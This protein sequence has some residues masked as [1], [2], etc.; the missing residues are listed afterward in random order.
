M[1]EPFNIRAAAPEARGQQFGERQNPYLPPG[2][3]PMA[4][5]QFNGINTNTTRP[6]VPDDQCW[7]MDNF[8]PL[9][10]R[11]LRTMYGIGASVYTASGTTVLFYEFAN[12][13]TLPI[14][15]VFLANGG[16]DQVNM[17]TN[18][19]TTILAASTITAP[20]IVSCG[21]TQWG[22][23]YV[24]IVADQTNGYWIWDG[25][26]LY[27]S[28]TLAPTMSITNGGGYYSST[29][30]VIVSGG[31]GHG[32][33]ITASLTNGAVTS[34]SLISPGTGYQSTD[35]INVNFIGTPLTGSGATLAVTSLSPYL[36]VT[37]IGSPATIASVSAISIVA[38]G[39]NYSPFTT[40]TFTRTISNVT[41]LASATAFPVVTNG[42]IT[43]VSITN[44]GAYY[45]TG[46]LATI[47]PTISITSNGVNAV[48]SAH[49]MPFGIS[50]T[51]AETYSGH[52][53][54]ISGATFYW[55]A[56]GAIDDF[57]TSNGGGNQTSNS[58]TLKV[59]HTK[60]I[61]ANGFLYF[62][63]D[64]S[65]DYISG[66][67][68]SGSPPTTSFTNQNA[69]PEVGT[70]YPQSVISVG[71]NIMFGN[72]YG[73]Q[74]IYG[75]SVR[76]ISEMLDGV[77]GNVANFGG[78]QLSSAEAT[79]F[80]NRVWMILIRLI[81]PVTGA[82]SN[83]IMMWDGDRKWWSGSQEITLTYIKHQEINS[84]ITAYGT[85]GTVV[86]PLFQQ[87]SGSLSKLVSS[88]L[89][90]APGGVMF[91]KASTR[92]WG[93]GQYYSTVSPNLIFSPDNEYGTIG[94]LTTITGPSSIGIFV[95]PPQAIGAIGRLTGM[96]IRTT[97][98]D[99]ALISA[100]L[101][102]EIIEYRG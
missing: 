90:D 58:S 25:A 95:T 20:S 28:G 23:Q 87:A 36:T 48:A 42:T 101:Q 16:V 61:A 68:T 19:V 18:A 64:S 12:I 27:T 80:G 50:G 65:V 15:V 34:L 39:A 98:A 35:I 32:I 53:W 10:Q 22:N 85:N 92:F 8:M 38:G 13:G 54:V 67:Q 88:R 59:K 2:P 45:S 102:D 30:G 81:D 3:K 93:L 5:E 44:G 55:T 94:T 96:T 83:K 4:M 29:P 77:Y 1:A 43:G 49:L 14:M 97:A 41:P 11:N 78:L 91:N 75:G 9:A 51:D 33:S 6:G 46:S 86:H 52:V 70:P 89:Y 71:R 47:F 82:T 73:V 84:V 72:S 100:M 62:V 57:A 26:L 60:L 56:P 74:G 66:V 79:I 31:M 99:F 76:K 40:L 7:W 37:V 69:D 21:M 63:N 24:I 17:N